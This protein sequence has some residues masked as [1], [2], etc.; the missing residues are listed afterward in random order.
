M[1]KDAGLKEAARFF[2]PAGRLHYAPPGRRALKA[3][4]L[5]APGVVS[6]G[7][8]TRASAC[9]FAQLASLISPLRIDAPPARFSDRIDCAG[10]LARGRGGVLD[11]LGMRGR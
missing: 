4:R 11:S 10:R 2:T 5:V 6:R 3:D 1:L 9:L 8:V 7:K